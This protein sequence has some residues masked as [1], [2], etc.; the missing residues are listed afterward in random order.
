MAADDAEDKIDGWRPSVRRM[1][2]VA[3]LTTGGGAVHGG[4][5]EQGEGEG[6]GGWQLRRRR[7]RGT[8]KVRYKFLSTCSAV[9][10][11]AAYRPDYRSE[12][13]RRWQGFCLINRK[14]INTAF[15]T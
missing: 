2:C 5:E 15:D 7:C 3:G 13:N 8:T 11:R 1:S 10:C 9:P 6:G 12:R 14:R 4:H